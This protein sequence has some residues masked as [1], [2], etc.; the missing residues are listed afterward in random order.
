LTERA[1]RAESVAEVA[2]HR[3]NLLEEQSN[4]LK[5][6]VLNLTKKLTESQLAVQAN[7]ELSE[8]LRRVEVASGERIAELESRLS[9]EVGQRQSLQASLRELELRHK[10]DQQEVRDSV[11]LAIKQSEVKLAQSKAENDRLK[12]ELEAE[13]VKLQGLLGPGGKGTN[14]KA[15]LQMK[16]EQQQQQMGLG[17]EAGEDGPTGTGIS[18]A[19][20]KRFN[21]MSGAILP[22]GEASYAATER[23]Q[24]QLQQRDEDARALGSQLHQLQVHFMIPLQ[25]SRW[26]CPA[27]LSYGFFAASYDCHICSL[28][29]HVPSNSYFA[30]FVR[31]HNHNRNHN[32][33]RNRRHHETLF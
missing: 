7:E 16:Q 30:N 32:R 3:K 18:S 8:R 27:Y 21:L 19:A 24:L 23:M 12:E 11:E 5:Q 15:V 31:N 33:N 20:S 4:E 17:D 6:Q 26:C 14:R 10:M 1:L 2:E 25:Y 29:F 22:S 28:Q 9:L 13:R